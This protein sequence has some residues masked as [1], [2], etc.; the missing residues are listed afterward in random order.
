MT[1]R[2]STACLALLWAVLFSV[3]A[4]QSASATAGTNTTAFTCAKVSLGATGEFADAH[5]DKKT[6][7]LNGYKHDSIVGSTEVE[8]T[9][10][11]T[12]GGRVRWSLDIQFIVHI[13][14]GCQIQ[15]GTG[16]IENSEPSVGVHKITGSL[17]RQ[18]SSCEVTEPKKCTVKE[19]IVEKIGSIESQEGLTGPKS[20]ANAMGLE[21]KAVA[22]KPLTEITLEG[23]ECALAGKPLPVE[24]SII[25]T[26]GP[27]EAEAQT[28]KWSG[29][30]KLVTTA[31]SMSK[32]STGG[33]AATLSSTTTYKMKGGGNAITATTVT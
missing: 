24:G 25:E 4:V 10:E 5:C 31:P 23:A 18:S 15:T 29:A 16:T 28:N 21:L 3:V 14:L 12:G 11:S 30:T 9:N 8:T 32:L 22:G 26:S 1:G 17:T 20:E 33:K 27:G 19:P 13:H 2:R 6:N 7:T